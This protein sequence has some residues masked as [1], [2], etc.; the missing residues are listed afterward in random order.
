V[1]TSNSRA[2]AATLTIKTS[3]SDGLSSLLSMVVAFEVTEEGVRL[4]S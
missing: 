3:C 1:H 4:A 2:A